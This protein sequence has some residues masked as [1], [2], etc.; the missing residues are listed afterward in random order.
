[1]TGSGAIGVEF[2]GTGV[3][4]TLGSFFL[5]DGPVEA[6]NNISLGFVQE[7]I[8]LQFSEGHFRGFF[9]I[10]VTPDFL[11]STYYSMRNVSEYY[12]LLNP[13]L[14]T[15]AHPYFFKAFRNLDGFAIANFSVKAG[16]NRLTRPI[17]DGIVLS[18][19]LKPGNH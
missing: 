4:S 12:F 14:D 16:A 17:S 8:D 1:L 18:G 13:C 19:A 9:A 3:T 6:S 10:S 2:A 7:N 11:N 5:T 15:C